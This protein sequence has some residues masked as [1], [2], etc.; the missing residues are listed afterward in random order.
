MPDHPAIHPDDAR[1]QELHDY[2]YRVALGLAAREARALAKLVG[3]RG[4]AH[5]LLIA[6]HLL[7]LM[8]GAGDAEAFGFVERLCAEL[9]EDR[10]D[11]RRLALE[12]AA[13]GRGRRG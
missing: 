10:D 13:K 11:A 8:D 2:H 7:H 12:A 9:A 4:D 6:S 1:A 3:R 5:R